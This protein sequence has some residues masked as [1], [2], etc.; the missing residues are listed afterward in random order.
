VLDIDV[1][2]SQIVCLILF[3]RFVDKILVESFPL[4]PV[5]RFIN[6]DLN[7]AA[8]MKSLDDVRDER[9]GQVIVDNLVVRS[10][11]RVDLFFSEYT[12]SDV[13]FGGCDAGE[14]S[15]LDLRAGIVEFEFR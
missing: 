12:I 1:E 2:P 3:K 11:V 14:Y 9:P 13:Y 7:L 5:E 8:I 15:F 6:R 10:Q 4:D